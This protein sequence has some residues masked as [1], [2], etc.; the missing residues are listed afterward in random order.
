[1]TQPWL[2]CSVGFNTKVVVQ[3]WSGHIQES[4]N[5][6]GRGGGREEERK[7]ERES[8]RGGG[9]RMIQRL[10]GQIIRLNWRKRKL[11]LG[12]GKFPSRKDT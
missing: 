8:G 7:R 5:E 3:S 6:R 9:E 4:N 2:G 12:L 10:N 11:W 1:M